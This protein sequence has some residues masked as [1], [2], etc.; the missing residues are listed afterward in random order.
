MTDA[1]VDFEVLWKSVKLGIERLRA[2]E[3]LKWYQVAERLELPYTELEG[4]E[5]KI[6]EQRAY[7]L[8]V[9]REKREKS[10]GGK[11][12]PSFDELKN[13]NEKL[14]KLGISNIKNEID[15]N[16]WEI[17]LEFF[18]N[19]PSND[20]KLAKNRYYGKW[21]GVTGSSFLE[22]EFSVFELELE[23]NEKGFRAT[24]RQL[25]LES[26]GLTE[27]N[28]NAF[29]ILGQIFVFVKERHAKELTIMSFQRPDSKDIMFLPGVFIGRGGGLNTSHPAAGKTVIFREQMFPKMEDLVDVCWVSKET[30]A[31]FGVS[32]N[33]EGVLDYV[34]ARVIR[35]D[36]V[37]RAQF[38]ACKKRKAR[39]K[40]KSVR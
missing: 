3:N 32:E 9:L 2:K 36:Q 38:L 30:L 7:K 40:R 6:R 37:L 18:Q 10:T 16:E 23:P 15:K 35:G 14:L 17:L 34:E 13:A 19:H 25:D 26:D 21:I 12:K 1:E 28:G 33:G 11:E 20:D 27:Y 5:R 22:K 8:S 39:K 29:F 31:E 24:Y 4:D